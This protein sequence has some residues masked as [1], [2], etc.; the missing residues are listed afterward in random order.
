MTPCKA[1]LSYSFFDPNLGHILI[2][3][4]KFPDNRFASSADYSKIMPVAI[5]GVTPER[6]KH[7][8][9][10]RGE[11]KLHESDL[12]DFGCPLFEQN[13]GFEAVVKY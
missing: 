13:I 7:L 6:E 5:W 8:A 10:I 3:K 2:F 11:Y 9:S 4:M 12:Q 1:A